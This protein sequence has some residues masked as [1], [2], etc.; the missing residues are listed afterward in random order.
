V[1]RGGIQI[2]TPARWSKA[3]RPAVRSQKS[4]PDDQHLGILQ[5]SLSWR[6]ACISQDILADLEIM[7]KANQSTISPPTATPRIPGRLV[8]HLLRYC[9]RPSSQGDDKGRRRLKYYKCV[10]TRVTRLAV[11]GSL[12]PEALSV[13]LFERLD[14]CFVEVITCYGPRHCMRELTFDEGFFD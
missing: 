7:P 2:G 3:R 1:P 13:Y 8:L 10:H 12:L 9:R 4:R 11:C 5:G 6:K 14:A